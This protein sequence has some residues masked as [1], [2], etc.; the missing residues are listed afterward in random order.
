MRSRHLPLN[1]ISHTMKRLFILAFTLLS[2]SII[3]SAATPALSKDRKAAEQTPAEFLTDF[4]DFVNYV[5]SDTT[6]T[7]DL[8]HRA[9]SIYNTYNRDFNLKY[10]QEMT[11]RQRTEFYEN[12]GRYLRNV[13]SVTATQVAVKATDIADKVNDKIDESVSFLRGL[14]QK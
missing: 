6:L 7:P 9:D 5:I 12:K 1:L 13:A 4:K 2:L 3:T 10:K 14:F 8:K 11:Q